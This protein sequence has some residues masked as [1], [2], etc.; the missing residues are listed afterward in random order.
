MLKDDDFPFLNLIGL[1]QNIENLIRT[2]TLASILEI[3]KSSNNEI[4][5]MNN[6]AI[7]FF[8][9]KILE[10]SKD[11]L[12]KILNNLF[13]EEIEL[14][15]I[16]DSVDKILELMASEKSAQKSLIKNDLYGIITGNNESYA[17][18]WERSNN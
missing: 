4:N 15:K 10:I 1:P 16:K 3:L 13:H 7:L 18:L 2:Q 5:D 17:T 11:E 9:G 14:N 6:I 12:E 8:S